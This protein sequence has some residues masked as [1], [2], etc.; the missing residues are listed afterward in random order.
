MQE[1]QVLFLGQEDLLQKKMAIHSTF[2]GGKSDE[3][4]SLVDYSPQGCKRVG[5][6]LVI[7]QQ[8]Q[9]YKYMNKKDTNH[10][11]NTSYL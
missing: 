11:H 1:T 2:L 4:R 9:K 8:E 5:H 3:Q 7:K 6:N 10:F